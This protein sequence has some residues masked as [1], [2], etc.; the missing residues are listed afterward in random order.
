MSMWYGDSEPEFSESKTMAQ[1]QRCLDI[2]LV[3]GL[4][5]AMRAG[6][7]VYAWIMIDDSIKSGT[8]L[9]NVLTAVGIWCAWF[10]A[11]RIPTA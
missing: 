2:L 9:Y 5:S 6:V 11:R 10:A 3:L 7:N 1:K 4:L 8:V